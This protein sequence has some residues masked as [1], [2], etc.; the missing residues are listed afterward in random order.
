MIFPVIVLALGLNGVVQGNINDHGTHEKEIE[1]TQIREL[2]DARA[3]NQWCR[4]N[5]RSR[6]SNGNYI[7]C[8]PYEEL[9]LTRLNDRRE[10]LIAQIA[11]KR[12][13]AVALKAAT[14]SA[15]EAAVADIGF[16]GKLGNYMGTPVTT[17]MVAYQ[18]QNE[19]LEDVRD[20]DGDD[21][22]VLAARLKVAVRG[23][24]EY[25]EKLIAEGPGFL[26]DPS[27]RL[28][29]T[30][31]SDELKAAAAAIT[32]K[33]NAEQSLADCGAGLAIGRRSDCTTQS[34]IYHSAVDSL[35]RA[36]TAKPATSE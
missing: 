28:I 17:A 35:D 32:A 26:R 4:D 14:P 16:F 7:N 30:M 24:Q 22:S 29:I 34:V 33:V 5:D 36:S 31:E 2:R 21:C 23:A 12:G 19:C 13:A 6:Q 1:A 8:E 15:D 20:G 3:A 10:T 18:N 27:H 9:Y 25:R 11:E